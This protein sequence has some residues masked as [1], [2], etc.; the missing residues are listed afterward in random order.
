MYLKSNGTVVW[1]PSS[2]PFV[3]KIASPIQ[4]LADKS[5]L[6]GFKTLVHVGHVCILEIKHSGL[7]HHVAAKHRNSMVSTVAAHE[8]Y[9]Y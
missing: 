9:I 5:W 3:R 7:G 2:R 4:D 1:Q 6:E 8:T